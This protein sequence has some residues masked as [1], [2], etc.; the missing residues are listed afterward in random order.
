MGNDASGVVRGGW[1]AS[2]G[3]PGST[4]QGRYWERVAHPSGLGSSAKELR[5]QIFVLTPDTMGTKQGGSGKSPS[6]A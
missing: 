3:P 2:A 1:A 4:G 5:T 6:C